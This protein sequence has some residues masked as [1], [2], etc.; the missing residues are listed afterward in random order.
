MYRGRSTIRKTV[1]NNEEVEVRKVHIST[2]GASKFCVYVDALGYIEYRL[3]FITL[4]KNEMWH[5]ERWIIDN[6]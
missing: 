2:Y 6:I 5:G 3:N 1:V 4:P